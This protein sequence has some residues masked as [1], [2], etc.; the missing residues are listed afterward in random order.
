MNKLEEFPPPRECWFS[1]V[2]NHQILGCHRSIGFVTVLKW[3]AQGFRSREFRAFW[4]LTWIFLMGPLVLPQ[5]C[6]TE[7]IAVAAFDPSFFMVLIRG[8]WVSP[9]NGR[10]YH[11]H[12]DVFQ[13]KDGL[14]LYHAE[15]QKKTTTTWP[16][17]NLW[18]LFRNWIYPLVI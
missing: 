7:K 11:E 8:E 2:Q 1:V 18:G 17:W 6:E 9:L 15:S 3:A 12:W 10:L 14:G 5:G 16:V 4:N 13:W